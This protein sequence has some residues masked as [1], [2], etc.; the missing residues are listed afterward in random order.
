MGTRPDIESLSSGKERINDLK[1]A[2][3]ME[4][5][6]ICGKTEI[7]TKIS[8]DGLRKAV[9]KGFDPVSLGLIPW[10][11]DR[12]RALEV[13]H[14]T[15]IESPTDWN[16]CATC[17]HALE[18]FRPSPDTAPGHKSREQE[19]KPGEIS[20]DQVLSMMEERMDQRGWS[21]EMKRMAL[22]EVQK[23]FAEE[24]QRGCVIA[25][26]ACGST[27]APAV[28]TLRDFRDT[29]LVRHYVGR[30][31][32]KTYTSIAPS[33]ARWIEPRRTARWLVR[34]LLVV[35]LASLIRRLRR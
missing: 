6:D 26:A 16:L 15:V 4:L 28:L 3:P 34:T 7:G 21:P 25:T 20:E 27:A 33:L 22:G 5:C 31:M 1:G 11:P 2:K 13:F 32:I 35:P 14:L 17:L 19:S 24:K 23:K 8:P 30:F 29:V 9:D 12:A 10:A 18:P